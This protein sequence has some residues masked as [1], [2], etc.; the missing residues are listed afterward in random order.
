MSL[1]QS[2]NRCSVLVAAFT[3]PS[4]QIKDFEIAAKFPVV[5]LVIDQFENCLPV[6]LDLLERGQIQDENWR[7][8]FFCRSILV[9]EEEH[10]ER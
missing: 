4:Q 9:V 1:D 8:I 7:Q 10:F 6:F 3:N 2:D 5:P